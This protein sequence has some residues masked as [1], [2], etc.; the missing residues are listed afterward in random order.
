[1]IQP[2]VRSAQW[3]IYTIELAVPADADSITIGL[4]LAG[5]GAAWFGDLALTAC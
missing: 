5:N 4:A 1:M 2:P 3:Q